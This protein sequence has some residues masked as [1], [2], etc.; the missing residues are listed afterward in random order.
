MILIVDDHAD[1]RRAMVRLLQFDGYEAVAVSCGGEATAYMSRYTPT[2][3]VLDY[4]M[5]DCNGLDVFADMKKDA[6]LAGIPVI[7]FSASGDVIREQALKA[8]VNGYVM[9][10]SLDWAHLLREI[11][12]HVGP[13][14]SSTRLPPTPDPRSKDIV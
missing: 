11:A 14:A 3:V 7:M 13:P 8:G 6:R 5:P 2:L 9:K 10:A 4:N 1:T 12:R